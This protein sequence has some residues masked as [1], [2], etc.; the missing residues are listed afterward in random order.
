MFYVRPALS[1]FLSLSDRCCTAAGGGLDMVKSTD[2]VAAPAAGGLP[3]LLP[4]WE[5]SLRAANKAPRT[6]ETCS[7]SA[8]PFLASP[9]RRFRKVW[10]Y[11][12]LFLPPWTGQLTQNQWYIFSDLRRYLPGALE[13]GKFL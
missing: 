3:G 11:I 10:Q 1:P 12:S 2:E 9:G 6:I 5:L 4:S 7:K 13:V 8:L